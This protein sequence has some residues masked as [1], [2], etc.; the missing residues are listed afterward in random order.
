MKLWQKLLVGPLLLLTLGASS[1]STLLLTN[2][3]YRSYGAEIIKAIST[4]GD[5]IAPGAPVISSPTTGASTTDTTPTFS[6]SCDND[7]TLITIYKNGVSNKT[8]IVVAGNTTWTVDLDAQSDGTAAYTATAKDASNNESDPS[9]SVNLT[10]DTTAP[11][12]P[13]ITAYPATG[14]DTTPTLAGTCAND[15]TSI[16]IRE[17]GS[18]VT[19]VAV[20]PPATTWS[21]DLPSQSVASHT[22]VA[23]AR[24]A[25]A[26]ESADSSSVGVIIYPAPVFSLAPNSNPQSELS[27]TSLTVNS[28]ALTNVLDCWASGI[29]GT[30]FVCSTGGTFTE[31]GSGTSPTTTTNTPFTTSTTAVQMGSG[32]KY[33][34]APNTTN[35]DITTEDFAIEIITRADPTNNAVVF[36]KTDGTAGW[37]VVGNGTNFTLRLTTSGTSTAVNLGQTLTSTVWN[38]H[39]CFVDRNEASTNGA[40]CYNNGTAN[41]GADLSARSASLTNSTAASIGASG[42]SSNG[43]IVLVR[44]WKCPAG[45]PNC[46]A[47]GATNATQWAAVSLERSARAWGVY[48]QIAGTGTPTI[49][50]RATTA[51]V[52]VLTSGVRRSYTV[53]SHAVRVVS[54]S[55]GT[56]YLSELTGTNILRFSDDITGTGWTATDAT[57]TTNQIATFRPDDGNIGDAID[58]TTPSVDQEHYV[59]YT[60][61]ATDLSAS[62]WTTSAYL[63][64]GENTWAF[65]RLSGALSI[66]ASWINLSDCTAGTVGAGAT[67]RVQSWGNGICRAGISYTGTVS[68]PS[69]DFGCASADND[70]TYTDGVNSTADCYVTGVQVENSPIMTTYIP[71]SG[72][73][74]TR[75]ADT[76]EYSSSS[77]V[78]GSYPYTFATKFFTI[79]SYDSP[80]DVYLAAVREGTADYFRLSTDGSDR[81]ENRLTL[82]SGGLQA[83]QNVTGDVTDG[84]LHECRSSQ[85]TNSFRLWKDSTEGT[86]DTTGTQGPATPT[87]IRVGYSVASGSQS[88]AVLTLVRLW[89]GVQTPVTAP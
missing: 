82:T 31:S 10:I 54:R 58:A 11:S 57:V 80:S 28:V 74:T 15:T 34:A 88:N 68:K 38:H 13:V 12:V 65:I 52:D 72:S 44:E 81:C 19:S 18:E 3:K 14:I 70:S 36:Q 45:T 49:M 55:E 60:H 30:N 42:A 78:P 27:S 6:G 47:G 23:R 71:T 62:T 79:A 46:F 61:P 39:I 25:L 83:Q 76:L 33:Y 5:V 56:G 20:T 50:T 29:S 59:S 9:N 51:S 53:G 64:A 40:I 32:T 17:G 85:E 35:G 7:T 66:P 43:P 22:Y 86:A 4:A 63:K 48:P 8:L 77:N 75:N 37:L 69:H 67:L 2:P 24:D 41:T 73:N 87:T 21:V 84:T 89:S 1:A 26:N 16:R